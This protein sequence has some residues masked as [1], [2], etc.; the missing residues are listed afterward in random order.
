MNATEAAND[1]GISADDVRQ[2][3]V[4]KKLKGVILGSGGVRVTPAQIKEFVQDTIPEGYLSLADA[5]EALGWTPRRVIKSVQNEKLPSETHYRRAIVSKEEIDKIVNPRDEL[6]EQPEPEWMTV[7]QAVKATGSSESSV[8]RWCQRGLVESKQIKGIRHVSTASLR[9]YLEGPRLTRGRPNEPAPPVFLSQASEPKQPTESP[10]KPP[11]IALQ[12][13]E[14]VVELTLGDRQL[15]A[16][17]IVLATSTSHA[18]AIARAH[19]EKYF[20][21]QV[22][23]GQT[24]SPGVISVG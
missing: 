17:L 7:R 18:A 2:L 6:D 15:S 24:L 19:A 23:G 22:S 21:V 3:L 12:Q 9:A 14:V 11:A 10:P 5:A 16:P 8:H 4:S 20:Q 13:F 1:L